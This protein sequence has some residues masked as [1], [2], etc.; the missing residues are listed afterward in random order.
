MYIPIC[1][2]GVMEENNLI[3][4]W[5]EKNDWTH[6]VF[7]LNDIFVGTILTCAFRCEL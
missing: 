5:T 7:G 3:N 4:I 6:D 1:F 2:V